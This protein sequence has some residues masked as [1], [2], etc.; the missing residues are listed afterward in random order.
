MICIPSETLLKEK[1]K[2]SFVSYYEWEMASGLGMRARLCFS[3][4]WKPVWF[5]LMQIASRCP[6]LFEFTCGSALVS[7]RPCCLGVPHP[8]WLLVILCPLPQNFLSHE[9]RDFL[10]LSVPSSPTMHVVQVLGLWIDSRFGQEEA[11]LIVADG[12]TGL[13]VQQNVIGSHFTVM[14]LQYKSTN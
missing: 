13:W 6:S 8:H 12:D 11:A 10:G 5:R 4:L 9:G 14:F 7:R 2:F 1:N 3:Q